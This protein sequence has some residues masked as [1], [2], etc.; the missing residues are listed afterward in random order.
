MMRAF[1]HNGAV[2]STSKPTR[3]LKTTKKV[4]HIDSADRDLAKYY[5]N[6]DFVV[7]LPRV[8]EN[9]LSIRLKGG[10]FPPVNQAAIAASSI[11]SITVVSSVV[12]VVLDTVVNYSVG[13]Y[14]G[15]TGATNTLNNGVFLITS[16][17]LLTGSIVIVNPGAVTQ[18]SNAGVALAY[19]PGALTHAYTS[20]QN[21]VGTYSSAA[22][23]RVPFNTF[24]FVI[25]VEGLNSSDETAVGAN[26]STF[27]DSMFA[28]IPAIASTIGTQTFIEYNDN[29]GQDNVAYYK[30]ALGKL[31]RLRI[32]MRTHAQQD[33]SGFMYWTPDGQPATAMTA[34]GVNFSLS[35]EIEMLDNSF[36]EFS[37]FETR[38]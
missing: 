33:K 22:D 12:T 13:Q 18:A 34:N 8:Y 36:D 4:V 32:R 2:V 21:Y 11:Q 38:L 17:S 14:V 6:G 15:I 29:S 9:V 35:L 16:V 27:S 26:R 3:Q 19:S 7:S 10:E 20:G 37:S 31:D 1:D 30:P 5:T 25:D 23:A 28:K 24:Y